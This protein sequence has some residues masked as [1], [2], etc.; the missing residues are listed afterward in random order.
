MVNILANDEFLVALNVEALCG[1]LHAATAEVVDRLVGI[2]CL[3]VH[4]D[5]FNGSQVVAIEAESADCGSSMSYRHFEIS[6][7][8]SCIGDFSSFGIAVIETETGLV[9]C[10]IVGDA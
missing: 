10:V 7:S 5:V 2:D 6:L 1:I 4:L 9:C 8:G 3:I